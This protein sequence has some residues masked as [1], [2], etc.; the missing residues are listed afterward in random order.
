[1]TEGLA[2]ALRDL[3]HSTAEAFA[4]D[5]AVHEIHETE[6][7]D[8]ATANHLFRIAQEAVNN[9]VKH[10]QA[11]T[12]RISLAADNTALTLSITNDGTRYQPSDTNKGLG[13]HTMSY[14]AKL[15]GGALD[16]TSPPDSGTRVVC[17]VR[18]TPPHPT[19]HEPPTTATPA[20]SASAS[21][22]PP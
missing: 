7:I 21:R 3:A 19:F 11:R 18:K 4:I 15:I 10:G 6:A 5:C 2:M 13:I 8:K 22:I 1:M 16:I 9:A 17:T 12:I 20:L 14:R